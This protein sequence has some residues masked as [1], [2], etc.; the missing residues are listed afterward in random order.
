VS[1]EYTASSHGPREED[2]A[3]VSAFAS[4]YELE[5]AD[6]D[7]AR[8][9]MSLRG[10]IRRWRKHSARRKWG[11]KHPT[12]GAYRAPGGPLAIPAGL[13]GVITGVFRIDE[14]PQATPR[15]SVYL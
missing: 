14:R 4:E 1:R 2:T 12:A 11:S 3:A 8:R 10:T 15:V 7:L 13:A 6:V 9:N 5:A